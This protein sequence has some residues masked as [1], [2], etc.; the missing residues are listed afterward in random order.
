MVSN[1][2]GTESDW[3]SVWRMIL[4]KLCGDGKVYFAIDEPQ[5]AIMKWPEQNYLVTIKKALNINFPILISN[6]KK[7]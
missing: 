7:N 1:I 5:E 4:N 2:P 6:I 3:K